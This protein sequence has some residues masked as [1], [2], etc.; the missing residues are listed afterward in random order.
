M[1]YGV[2][3]MLKADSSE[4]IQQLLLH[5][6]QKNQLQKKSEAESHKRLNT[7]ALAAPSRHLLQVW[8]PSFGQNVFWSVEALSALKFNKHTA[9]TL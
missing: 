2:F 4:T 9:A 1:T 5:I 8:G 3:H 7:L 6:H